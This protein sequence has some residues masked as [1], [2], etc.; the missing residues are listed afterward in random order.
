MTIASIHDRPESLH[1]KQWFAIVDQLELA[2]ADEDVTST[3]ELAH[4]ILEVLEDLAAEEEV[5]VCN[6][7]IDSKHCVRVPARTN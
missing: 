6:S 2:L 4:L 1:Q 3:G 7:E 5:A